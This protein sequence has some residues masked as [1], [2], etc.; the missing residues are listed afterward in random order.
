M[1]LSKLIKEEHEENKKNISDEKQVENITKILITI[2]AG[3]F[4]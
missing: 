3:C 1:Y 4:S 2:S